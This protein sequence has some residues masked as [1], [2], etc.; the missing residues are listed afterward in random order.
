MQ[1][2]APRSIAFLGKRALSI[3]IDQP[4]IAW[5]RHPS[6]FAGAVVW[7]LPNPSGLNRNFT[8]EALVEAYADL[9]RA[10]FKGPS[11]CHGSQ[12]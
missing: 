7:V 1:R 8:L 12:S 4:A 11:E 2:Y 3:M 10:L 5:G 6:K 9:R